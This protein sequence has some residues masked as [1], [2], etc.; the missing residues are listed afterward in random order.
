LFAT[1]KRVLGPHHISTK[2][3][4]SALERLWMNVLS[5]NIWNNEGNIYE[6]DQVSFYSYY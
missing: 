3:V 1:S 6:L 5:G 2:E 4:T